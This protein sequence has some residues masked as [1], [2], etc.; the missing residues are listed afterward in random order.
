MKFINFFL[1]NSLVLFQTFVEAQVLT[2]NIVQNGDGNMAVNKLRQINSS[3]RDNTI[4]ANTL[5]NGD[6]NTAFNKLRAF[7]DG[8]QMTSNIIQKGDNNFGAAKLS[9]KN[10]SSIN[11]G[12]NNNNWDIQR[13]RFGVSPQNSWSK[14]NS[15]GQWNG[16][17]QGW[18]GAVDSAKSRMGLNTDGWNKNSNNGQWNGAQQNA[19][20]VVDNLKS[21]IGLNTDRAGWRN[22]LDNKGFQNQMNGFR[23]F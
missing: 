11:N 14:N 20:N 17:Q 18:R 10:G 1:I 16:A 19:K 7:G 8:N 2:S 12:G 5:Q 21:K 22:T 4:T 6:R 9:Y 3:G 23:K 15:N 13:N